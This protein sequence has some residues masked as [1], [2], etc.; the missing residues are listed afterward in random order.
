MPADTWWWVFDRPLYRDW[1]FIAGLV[2]SLLGM[3]WMVVRSNEVGA[4]AFVV[5]M[6]LAA[7][8]GVL[9][10]GLIGG[11]VREYLRGRRGISR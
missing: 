3:I 2:L 8:S 1:L 11:T 7:P 6:A 10:T 9:A 4:A 5:S